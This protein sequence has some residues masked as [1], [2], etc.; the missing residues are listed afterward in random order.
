MKFKSVILA[1]ILL[2]IGLSGY[3]SP[4]RKGRI[5]L[6][7]PDGSAFNAH[8]RGDEFFRIKT[9]EDGHAVIQDEDGWWCYAAFGSDG[10]RRSSGCRVGGPVSHEVLD[11]SR[12]IPFEEM[13]E[14]AGNARALVQDDREPLMKRMISGRK[15]VTKSE[16]E[17]PLTKH[18]LVILAQFRDKPFSHTKEDFERLLNEE[19]YALNGATGCAKEYFDDQFSGAVNFEF[20][21]SEIVTLTRNRAYF[22]GNSSDGTDKAPAEMIEEA[23]RLADNEIDFS[24]YDDDEDGTV[25]NV[26][27]FFAGPD[28]AEGAS[29]DCIWSHAW[30]IER[31]A[32]ITIT[33][34]GKK[35][36]RYACTSELARRHS[37][38]V[39]VELLNSIGTF[40]HEY[41]HTFG[42]PDFY[43]TDYEKADGWAAGLW[44]STS[45]MDSGNQNNGGNT[46]PYLNAIERSLLG[47]AE[48]VM[49]TETG[50]YTLSP[51]QE[52]GLFYRLDTDTED[53]YFLFECREETGWDAYIGGSGMLA[54]HIDRS[55][56][57]IKRW[58]IGNNVNTDAGHQC[59]DL[60]EADSRKDSFVDQSEFST[61]NQNITGIFFPYG[62]A[63]SLT[64]ESSPG[65]ISWSGAGNDKGLAGI[66]KTQ[67]GIM[68]NLIGRDAA[69]SP[70][71]VASIVAES[72]TDAA[73]IRFESSYAYEG[74]ATV[75]WGRTGSEGE[76]VMV[77]PYA[78]GKYALILEGLESTGKTYSVTVSFVKDEIEGE[79][80][81]ISFMTK[82][83]PS[84]KWPYIWFG[85]AE[86]NSDGSFVSGAR[87]PLRV[88]NAAHAA[89]IRWFFNGSMISH[90]GDGYHTLTGSGTLKAVISWEDGSSDILMKEIIIRQE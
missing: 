76:T 27:V 34:D 9:T 62:E 47:L 54:Y 6:T 44:G 29:E 42:L 71:A 36:D 88:Y 86:R 46:P 85:S 8:F 64:G 65:L 10:T 72:F 53:E 43:D 48:P 52:E 73:I 15:A 51:I 84:V 17:G 13:A 3:A 89:E 63:T 87:I 41:S 75:T 24:L 25:D 58:N 70:P 19:G 1:A 12:M 35:I 77:A 7:Q 18:G 26:F 61:L 78:P 55:S 21:V 90:D 22:G 67:D 57:A 14:M 45:L 40:C 31:G 20:Q 2:S 66:R 49:L 69:S 23:C 33:L 81:T 50:A 83:A 59:A 4:A 37:G 74:E 60:I 80:K 68:F 79:S 38:N 16:T 39:I 5:V 82:R 30:Y 56:G 11:A 32:G 28:E